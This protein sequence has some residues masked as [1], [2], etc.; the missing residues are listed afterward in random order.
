MSGNNAKQNPE[1]E[2]GLDYKAEIA[3]LL[4]GAILSAII[5]VSI[6]SYQ[7]SQTQ[8]AEQKSLATGY[9][10]EIDNIGPP[11][12]KFI[13]ANASM[14]AAHFVPIHSMDNFYPPYGLYYSNRADISKF[15]TQTS[16]SLYRFYYHLLRADDQRKLFNDFDTTGS[17]N[18]SNPGDAVS[19]E[20]IHTGIYLNMMADLNQ[21]VSEIPELKAQLK[22]YADS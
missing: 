3:L 7:V 9:L 17:V 13:A 2:R 1:K 15:D 12:A 14:D 19:R 6:F 10:L 4:I 18:A 22:K 11:L 16:S 21:S 5:S 20:E 8:K